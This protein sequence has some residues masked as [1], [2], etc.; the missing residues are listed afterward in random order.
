MVG[1]KVM[2]IHQLQQV[3]G[4]LEK[5]D[6]NF[7]LDRWSSLIVHTDNELSSVACAWVVLS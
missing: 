4:I 7:K 6:W 5:Q 2:A 1:M 3:G